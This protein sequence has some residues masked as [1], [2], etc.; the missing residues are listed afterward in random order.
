MPLDKASLFQTLRKTGGCGLG[1]V[2]RCGELA[3]QVTTF[4][5]I[6]PPLK[7]GELLDGT[8]DRRFR[9]PW[10]MA[11]PGSFAASEHSG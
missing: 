4:T 3:N 6:Y 8:D 10:A 11:S 1:K 9:I 5:N 2:Q 7:P